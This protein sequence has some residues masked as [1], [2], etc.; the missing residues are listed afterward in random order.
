VINDADNAA[1]TP[2]SKRSDAQIQLRRELG[3]RADFVLIPLIN[4]NKK[5]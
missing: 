5:P 3:L 1:E 2:P 4:I